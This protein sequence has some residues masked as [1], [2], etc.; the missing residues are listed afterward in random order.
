MDA[1]PSRVSDLH[2][3]HVFFNLLVS[4]PAHPAADKTSMFIQHCAPSRSQSTDVP[5]CHR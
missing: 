4:R 1:C 3:H 2:R 5:L